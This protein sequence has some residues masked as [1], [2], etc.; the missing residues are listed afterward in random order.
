MLQLHPYFRHV[1]YSF[2][3]QKKKIVISATVYSILIYFHVCM[4]D[5]ERWRQERWNQRETGR[6]AEGFVQGSSQGEA[7]M[8]KILFR[9]SSLF[10]WA[11]PAGLSCSLKTNLLMSKRCSSFPSRTKIDIQHNMPR[12]HWR[13]MRRTMILKRNYARDFKDWKSSFFSLL[14]IF[15]FQPVLH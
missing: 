13:R 4:R 14:L 9:T 12:H 8:C 6:Q 11:A 15:F 10:S 5:L 7:A 3:W 2:F 1:H